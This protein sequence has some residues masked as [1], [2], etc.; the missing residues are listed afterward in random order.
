ML[1]EDV[2]EEKEKD[3]KETTSVGWLIDVL[4]YYVFITLG[5]FKV[6]ERTRI[7]P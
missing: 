2:E 5:T 1:E 6:S 4:K 7:S 3:V